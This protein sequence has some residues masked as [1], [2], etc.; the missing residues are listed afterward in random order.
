MT[1]RKG[2]QL[3]PH[4]SLCLLLPGGVTF[5]L[6]AILDNLTSTIVMISLLRKIIPGDSGELRKLLGA[7]VVIAANAGGAWTPMGDVTTTMLWIGGQVR[8]RHAF[9]MPCCAWHCFSR[10]V[11][12]PLIHVCTAYTRR[13]IRQVG[14]QSGAAGMDESDRVVPSCPVLL[15]HRKMDAVCSSPSP[16]STN[17]AFPCCPRSTDTTEN[18]RKQVTQKTQLY[19]MATNPPPP[20]APQLRVRTP[21]SRQILP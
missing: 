19:Y 16:C 6:S 13:Y 21:S 1:C 9:V 12:P 14:R 4:L 5:F 20:P 18:N 10:S 8:R 3:K 17:C 2:I 15:V 7:V 11:L